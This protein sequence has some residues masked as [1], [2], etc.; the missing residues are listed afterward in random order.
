MSPARYDVRRVVKLIETE[1]RMWCQG[2]GGAGT[3]SSCLM[4]A[5]FQIE[6]MQVLDVDGSSGCITTQMYF[7]T[8]ELDM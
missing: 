5:R 2:L 8:T 4:G 1:G 6:T 7:N 3:W